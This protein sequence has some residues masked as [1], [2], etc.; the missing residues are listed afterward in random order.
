MMKNKDFVL[1]SLKIFLVTILLFELMFQFK[2]K[3]N[4]IVSLLSIAFI[5]ALGYLLILNLVASIMLL[6]GKFPN[7]WQSSYPISFIT[8]ML[9]YGL[10]KTSLWWKGLI[11]FIFG[12]LLG[13]FIFRSTSLFL[14][15][16]IPMFIG[17]SMVF[18]LDI[19]VHY[20]HHDELYFQLFIPFLTS[21]SSGIL[22]A[23][24]KTNKNS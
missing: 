24:T 19:S 20:Y 15:R 8:L 6:F 22:F 3:S 1:V 9:L 5:L 21:F 10:L 17:I 14:H 12:F 11:F 2:I 4:L 13:W 16:V 7:Y 18:F 23:L